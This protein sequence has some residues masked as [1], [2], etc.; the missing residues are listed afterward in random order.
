ML[1]YRDFDLLKETVS[2]LARLKDAAE[3]RTRFLTRLYT[4]AL[5]EWAGRLKMDSL[6]LNKL[7]VW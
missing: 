4:S 3:G 6:Q 5:E 2:E 1:A 7:I